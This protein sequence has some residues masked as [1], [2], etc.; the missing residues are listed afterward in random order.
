[1]KAQEL[2]FF[3]SV[4]TKKDT[5]NKVCDTIYSKEG[6]TLFLLLEQIGHVVGRD[7]ICCWKR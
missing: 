6:F 3:T 4:F 1:M 7:R 5:R 2:A